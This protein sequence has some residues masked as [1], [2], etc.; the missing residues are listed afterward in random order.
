MADNKLYVAVKPTRLSAGITSSASTF[1]VAAVQDRAGNTLTMADFGDT[2]YGVF[3]PGKTNEEQFTFTGISGTTVTFGSRGLAM[4]SPYTNVAA[5]QKAHAAGTV[6]ILYTNSPAFYDALTNKTDDESITGTWTFSESA[7]PRL[8]A[9]GTWGVGTEEYLITKRYADALAIAGAPNGTTSQ[10]GIFE[11]ATQAE[12]NAGTST[13]G[14]GASL[15]ATPN[16]TALTVQNGLWVFAA[17]SVGTDAYAITLAPA[18][19][20]YVT[21]QGFTFSAGT[22]NTGAATLNVNAL[23]AKTIKKNHDQDLETGDIESGKIVQVIYDGTNFQMQS[24]QDSMPTT[25]ILTEMATYFGITDITGAQ[26]NTLIGGATTDAQSLHNHPILQ[27]CQLSNIDNASSSSQFVQVC[28]DTTGDNIY[29]MADVAGNRNITRYQKDTTSGAYYKSAVTVTSSLASNA[30]PGSGICAGTTYVWLMS[31]NSAG[32]NLLIRRFDKN[33]ANETAITVSGTALTAVVGACA[34]NDSTLYVSELAANTN[35]SVYTIS[36]TTA[37]RGTT[38]NLTGLN[39]LQRS[40]M[41]FDGTNIYSTDVTNSPILIV[42]FSTAGGASVSSTAIEVGASIISTVAAFTP[43]S[44]SSG[45][46]IGLG[47]SGT[48]RLFQAHTDLIPHSTYAS[49]Q[50]IVNITAHQK[51]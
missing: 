14:T 36:G 50:Q 19:T 49:S 3:E 23:G 43:N 1:T 8:A 2:G 17:D 44:G 41:F 24:V 22:A 15:V 40:G 47:L 35:V 46:N 16:L 48:G 18:V 11:L 7:I 39:G 51:P 13:G 4:K 9:A 10:K 30:T 12:N 6:V 20:A 42:K 29:V 32:S 28:S 26:S 31:R 34:G 21:G 45:R 25:A 33:L 37:T 27:F 38:I 5:N